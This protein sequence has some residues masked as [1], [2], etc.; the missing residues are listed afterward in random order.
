MGTWQ[1]PD[2]PVTWLGV[3]QS[4]HIVQKGVIQFAAF[5]NPVHQVRHRQG[6]P[7]VNIPFQQ[8]LVQKQP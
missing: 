7:Q 5:G 1:G 2:Q 4:Q 8:G 6:S 3:S